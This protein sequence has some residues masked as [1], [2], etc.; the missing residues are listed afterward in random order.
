M[1]AG[2]PIWVRVSGIMALA[3]VAVIVGSM[4]L[5][6]S[7]MEGMEHN[8]APTGPG[9]PSGDPAPSHVRPSH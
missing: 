2:M 5:G 3:L 8:G 4:L 6:S 9:A 1:T 7:P